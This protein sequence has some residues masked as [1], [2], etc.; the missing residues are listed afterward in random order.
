MTAA[1][2]SR[3]CSPGNGPSGICLSYLLSGH[4]PYFSPDASHPN[5]LLHGKL[6]EQPHLSLLEQVGDARSESFARQR[7]SGV[8]VWV[9]VRAVQHLLSSSS[10]RTWST[11]ARGWR[12]DRPILWRCFSIRCCCLTVTLAWNTRLRWSGDMSPSEPSRTWCW[13]RG[14]QGEPGTYVL[15]A[16]LSH[17]YFYLFFSPPM[18]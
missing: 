10:S 13:A 9:C 8:C 5:P 17:F 15:R 18:C 6:G 3:L 11:C 1:P 7:H 14:H 16:A 12:G 4:T 2:P